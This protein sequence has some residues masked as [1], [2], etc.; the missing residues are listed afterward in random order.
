MNCHA[1]GTALSGSAK[2]CHKCG[3]PV[4]APAGSSGAADWRRGVPWVLAGLAVGALVTVLALR[5]GRGGG[6]PAANAPPPAGSVGT[7]DIS[8]MSTEEMAQRLFDRTM[9]LSEEGKQDSVAFFG[10][11]ALQTYA[12]LPALD[13]HSRYDVGMLQLAVGNPQ[14]ALAQAD[15]LAAAVPRHLYALVLRARAHEALGNQAGARAAFADYLKYEAAE[16]AGG[17]P[18]YTAHAGTL[19]AFKQEALGRAGGS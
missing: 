14:G 8:Q 15:T 10:P 5:G 16:R 2:F 11:M 13:N 7:T 12:Q 4:G 1:C 17:R 9:R 19:D 3:A 6:A 18:E